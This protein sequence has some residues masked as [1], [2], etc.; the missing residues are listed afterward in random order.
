MN[1]II[2]S[3]VT[4]CH[5]ETA[6]LIPSSTLQDPAFHWYYTPTT[7][8]AFHHGDSY[9]TPELNITTTYYL[10][11]STEGSC[12]NTPRKPVT[13]T[14]EFC[15]LIDCAQFTDK[16]VDEDGPQLGYTQLTTDWDAIPTTT[17]DSIAYYINGVLYSG[18]E[19][20]S[21]LDA[22]F[23]VGVSTVTVYG[24]FEGQ[25]DICEFLV[26][27]ELVCP[28]SILDSE[29]HEYN[30]TKL[31]GLC[32]TSNL[33]ATLYADGRPIFFAHPYY[34]H[35]YPDSSA[36]KDIF[37]L[38]Y[39]WYS[40]VDVPEGYTAE[41][42]GVVQGICPD[43]WHVPS[44]AEWDLLEI[45]NASQLKSTMYWLTPPAPGTDDFGFDARPAGWYNSIKVRYEDLLGF[46]GWWA[47]DPNSGS[48]DAIYYT[49][50]YYCNNIH[51]EMKKRADGLSV[52]CV[53]NY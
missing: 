51:T 16:Y 43:D 4:I 22:H 20:A 5:G 31:S 8:S 37:G 47:L 23:N 13:V 40:A 35:L 52:R 29:G 41:L 18:G 36:Y 9:T 33:Q 34:S 27:V 53:M 46:T 39:T 24:Y 3:G 32:W 2:I 15:T 42:S 48:R 6:T 1:D 38:L 44:Q 21:L 28:T 12:E 25:V 17:L 14:V 50:S 19:T 49:I 7:P 10:T 26:I 30:V 11:V 45:Y